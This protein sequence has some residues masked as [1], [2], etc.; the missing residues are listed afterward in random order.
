M[1]ETNDEQVRRT[2][3]E[4]MNKSYGS[5]DNTIMNIRRYHDNNK[6]LDNYVVCA[7]SSF[8]MREIPE[9]KRSALAKL[10]RLQARRV[11]DFYG[12][13]KEE[14]RR[15]FQQTMF[16]LGSNGKAYDIP[17]VL[18]FVERDRESSGEYD[19]IYSVMSVKD[20]VLTRKEAPKE[21]GKNRF[22]FFTMEALR[23]LVVFNPDSEEYSERLMQICGRLFYEVR[24][25]GKLENLD[26]CDCLRPV[27]ADFNENG[28]NLAL[29]C[30]KKTNHKSVTRWLQHEIK[31]ES[32]RWQRLEIWPEI[33]QPSAERKEHARKIVAE[34]EARILT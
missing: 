12:T 11:F 31:E 18:E 19:P 8:R 2:I 17:L 21:Q 4:S 5:I 9:A 30:A 27:F 13:E 33:V 26:C 28:L 6:P 29:D 24:G 14:N 23:R 15:T 3:M 25:P 32:G 34:L 16:V 22:L 10:M 20:G 7:T 1:S